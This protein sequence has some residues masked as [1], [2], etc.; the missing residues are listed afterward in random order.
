[1]KIHVLAIAGTMTTPLA[2]EL[3]RLGHQVSGS[4]QDKIYPPV[5]TL[6]KRAK[7]P[8]NK[9]INQQIN[10]VIVGS[11]F[12]KF[13]LTRQQFQQTKAKSIP[14]ISATKYITKN[15]IKQN[16]ILVAGSFGKSTITSL[17][18]AIFTKARIDPSFMFGG[19]SLDKT[20][21]L[22]INSSPWSIVE[23]DESINGLDTKAKF[24]YYPKKYLVLTSADW[25]H[26]ESYKTQK[27]NFN[28]FKKLVS[29]LP[30]DGLLVYNQQN[31]PAKKLASFAKCPTIS[32]NHPQADYHIK[33]IKIKPPQTQLLLKTTRNQLS[34]TTS[35]LGQHNFQNILAAVALS[36]QL[37]LDPQIIQAA[38]QSYRGLARRLQLLDLRNNILFFDDFAQSAPR[39]SSA[40]RAI[41]LHYP[42]KPIHVFFDA[43]ASFLQHRSSLE[44]LK[45]AFLPAKTIVLN[46]IKYSPKIAKSSRVTAHHFQQEIG[47]KLKYLPL[48]NQILTHFQNQ[49]QPGHIFIHFS[50]GHLQSLA[51]VQK[52]IKQFSP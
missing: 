22:L 35:L 51:T 48:E 18:A 12:K 15:L 45:Q 3:K 23:A 40:L 41:K 50:S 42:K 2:I 37:G 30:Q 9:P 8:L 16:S 10:L 32:Y 38:I 29:D 6:L 25:E 19:Q 26:K 17:L 52:I 1:M 7:I 11:S 31:Q 33:S 14:F 44:G 36:Q 13:T 5:S 39:I 43:R 20:P 21:A 28:S 46:K 34:I 24:H 27:D 47:S 49:L 4:D